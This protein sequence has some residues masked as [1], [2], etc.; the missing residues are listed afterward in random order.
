MALLNIGVIGTSLK[1]NER[2]IP[3]HPDH[4]DS[5]PDEIRRHLIFESNYGL[6]FGLT[7]NIIADGSGGI[8]SREEIFSNCDVILLPKPEHEDF[9]NMR[10]NGIL[11]GWAHVVQQIEFTQ[12]SI[13][14][15]LTLIAW[16]SMNIWNSNGEYQ[17]HIFQKNNEIAGYAG[18]LDALRLLGIDGKYGPHRKAIL[19]GFGFV[20]QGAYYALRGLGLRILLFSRSIRLI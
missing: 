7:D 2:R 15:R 11:W 8:A 3:I 19:I 14:R 10:K 1:E 6:P 5:I 18:V 16:E 4:I 12:A 20:G 9:L 17:T 13:D